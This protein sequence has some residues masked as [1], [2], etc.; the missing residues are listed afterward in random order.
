MKAPTSASPQGAARACRSG[1]Y[2]NVKYGYSE[3][4][5]STIGGIDL[6]YIG[7]LAVALVM[8]AGVMALLGLGWLIHGRH[9]AP[10]SRPAAPRI[11]TSTSSH[12]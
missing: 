10:A 6:G 7:V 5:K 4:D 9:D 1:A 11:P 3:S 8:V 2:L 12:S